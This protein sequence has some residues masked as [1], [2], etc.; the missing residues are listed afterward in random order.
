TEE[1]NSTKAR[2]CENLSL[3]ATARASSLAVGTGWGHKYLCLTNKYSIAAEFELWP[4][5]PHNSI[6]G[7]FAYTGILGF[8][9]FWLAIPTA[10]FFNARVARL[11]S[12]RGLRDA[13]VIGAAQM[14]VCTNQ[15]YGDMGSFSPA[16]LY[17]L[18]VSYAI[19]LRLPAVAGVW[20]GAGSGSVAKGATRIS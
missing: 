18:A 17:V 14:I 12:T 6:L 1:D 10:V 11:G 20:P 13:G 16:T 2:N 7:L 3:I 4:Y 5:I 15:L 9:G 8:A 19:A